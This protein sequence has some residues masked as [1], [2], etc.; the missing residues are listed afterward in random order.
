[1]VQSGGYNNHNPRDQQADLEGWGKRAL[2]AH[3]YGF[4]GFAPFAAAVFVAHLAGGSA[5]LVVV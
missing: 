4:E 1:M 3:L 2:S 5:G